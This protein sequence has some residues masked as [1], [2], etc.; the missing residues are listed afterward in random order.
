[1]NL[2]F[3]LGGAALVYAGYRWYKG[4]HAAMATPPMQRRPTAV[5]PAPLAPAPSAPAPQAW[6]P[7]QIYV[8]PPL[9]GMS[10]ADQL[11][12]DEPVYQNPIDDVPSQPGYAQPEDDGGLFDVFSGPS[13]QGFRV[14]RARRLRRRRG[15]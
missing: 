9:P 1:M 8:G 11:L 15:L 3:P 6:E 2:L 13:D 14:I 10:K 5:A 4:K 7:G 12:P